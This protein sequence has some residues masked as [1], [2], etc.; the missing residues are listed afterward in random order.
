VI[1]EARLRDGTR[2]LM[3]ELLPQDREA[4]REGYEE[5]S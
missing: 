5:L 3:L 1:T 2:A 4:V